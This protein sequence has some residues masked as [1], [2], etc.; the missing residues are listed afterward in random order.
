MINLESENQKKSLFLS[1]LQVFLE[2]EANYS[3]VYE[4]VTSCEDAF[5]NE[6]GYEKERKLLQENKQ[7]NLD[8]NRKGEILEEIVF[9]LFSRIASL[10]VV[11][12]NQAKTSLGQIDLQVL[13][14]DKSAYDIL[15]LI[16]RPSSDL[17]IGECKNFKG[18]PIELENIEKA[19]WRS[20]KGRS[21][22]FFIGTKY[23]QAAID[24]IRHFNS[25]KQTIF[26]GS[27]GVWMVPIT[28]DMIEAVVEN[29]INF[30]SFLKWSI[31][32]S[33]NQMVIAQYL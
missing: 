20:C 10:E 13:I 24:E 33:I 18:K 14:S 3:R 21:L 2:R 4:G 25:Y 23:T 19:C 22:Q 8:S 16:P 30:L 31:K 6:D 11:N 15:G 5:D 17:I 26:L 29:N 27:E 9:S 1:Q 12:R 28:I 7:N 32:Y